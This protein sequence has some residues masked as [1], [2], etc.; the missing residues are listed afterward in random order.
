M[1]LG[2]GPAC[3]EAVVCR[4]LSPSSSQQLFKGTLVKAIFSIFIPHSLPCRTEAGRQPVPGKVGPLDKTRLRTA[5]SGS[6]VAE[7]IKRTASTAG[8]LSCPIPSRTRTRSGS[9]G[10][11]RTT[12]LSG[13]S[14]RTR[15]GAAEEAT[16]TLKLKSRQVTTSGGVAIEATAAL[17]GSMQE[18]EGR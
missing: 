11:P 9:G 15:N 12:R 4:P 17:M 10:S 3:R 1:L 16:T 13:R 8:S 2:T 18:T 6:G 14:P 7:V 5:R